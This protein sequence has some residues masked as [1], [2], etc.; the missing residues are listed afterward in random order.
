MVNMGVSRYSSSIV[1]RTNVDGDVGGPA[2][3][4]VGIISAIRSSYRRANHKV[5]NKDF[6]LKM[7]LV[8]KNPAKSG[9]V[10]K[11]SLIFR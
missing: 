6:M 1:S 4:G 8:S 2:S 11:K 3:N 10:G 7:N 5:I 9:G